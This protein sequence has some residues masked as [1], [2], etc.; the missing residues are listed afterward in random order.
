MGPASLG[1]L[2]VRE[3]ERESARA[4]ALGLDDGGELVHGVLH[5]PVDDQVIILS[6]GRDFLAG[7]A[8]PGLHGAGPAW[9]WT[10][11]SRD[12][13]PGSAPRGRA[14]PCPLPRAPR[15]PPRCHTA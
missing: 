6:P 15:P 2:H 9:W 8:E 5:V 3:S 11:S 4:A 14:W 7:P 13:G 1:Y 12:P 10:R